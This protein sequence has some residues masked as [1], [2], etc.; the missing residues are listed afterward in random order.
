MPSIL[1]DSSQKR[2][3]FDAVFEWHKTATGGGSSIAAMPV[4]GPPMGDRTPMYGVPDTLIAFLRERG[5]SVE[6]SN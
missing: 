4:E 5:F 2:A 6:I 1:I 3:F